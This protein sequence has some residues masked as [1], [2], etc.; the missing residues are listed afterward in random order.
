MR[1]SGPRWTKAAATLLAILSFTIHARLVR[2]APLE[3]DWS[4]PEGC[5]SRERILAAL[6]AALG[7]AETTASPAL[8]V[9]GT[10]TTDGSA[11][12]VHLHIEDAAGN[13]I[14]ERRIRHAE[15]S[16][17]AIEE[18]TAIVL[19]M[20]ISAAWPRSDG[21][22]HTVEPNLPPARSAPSEAEPAA[23]A[24]APG[25]P[26]AS[27]RHGENARPPSPAPERRRAPSPMTV[28]AAAV[29]S[30]GLL[31]NVAFGG[32]LRWTTVLPA[33]LVIGAEASFEAT[34]AARAASGD[35][36]FR[37]YDVGALLGVR[38]VRERDFE[39]VPLLTARAGVM[40]AIVSGLASNADALRVVGSSSAGVLAR[41]RLGP[42]LH[43]EA[44]PELR[45]PFGRDDFQVL[46]NDKLL[47][48]HRPAL[49][50]GRLALGVGWA[51][52]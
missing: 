26:P 30:V 37:Y 52:R 31:P 34:W 36:T 20:M 11:F 9:R 39:L 47:H 19:A 48:V 2:A 42:T 18:P 21:E 15:R 7:E 49:F 6:H 5:P 17:Q 44:L 29:T 41:L 23:P 40:T 12:I 46:A 10:V 28:S 27:R 50:E 51:F 14:G 25:S 1:R 13:D 8:F 4:G 3:L 35:A 24:E 33:P 16:C 43:L 22:A 32:A 38:L 45:V